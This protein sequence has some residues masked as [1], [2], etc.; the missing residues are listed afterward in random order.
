MSL[1]LPAVIDGLIPHRPPMLAVGELVSLGDDEAVSSTVFSAASPFVGSDS[2]VEEA[3]L[4]EMMAQTF[5]AAV[6]ARKGRAGPSSGFLVG[7][8]RLR[9]QGQARAGQA[10]EVAVKI[11]SRVEDFSVIEG[12]ASQNGRPLASGQITIFV[13]EGQKS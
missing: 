5:A 8:K 13:P 9:V 12:R 6:A 3:L 11:I 10:V 2:L 4:F 7:I 1:Q